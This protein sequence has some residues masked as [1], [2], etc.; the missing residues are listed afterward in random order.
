MHLQD[1][2]RVALEISGITLKESFSVAPGR[3]IVRVVVRDTE[4]QTMAARNVGVEIP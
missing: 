2:T 4:G 1:Q 3:Y